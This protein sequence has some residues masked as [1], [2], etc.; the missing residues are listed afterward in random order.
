M[1]SSIGF[2]EE[3]CNRKFS[4]RYPLQLLLLSEYTHKQHIVAFHNNCIYNIFTGCLICI[5]TF[6]LNKGIL[7]MQANNLY[8]Q[9]SAPLPNSL[10]CQFLRHEVS[11]SRTTKTLIDHFSTT[12][13]KRILR[14]DVLRIGMVDHYMVYG[15]RKVNAWRLK[16]KNKPKILETRSFTKYDKT[17]FINDL[18]QCEVQKE[19]ASINIYRT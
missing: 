14:A 9:L 16:G 18:R 5:E 10:I 7:E 13:P 12:S 3:I 19:D 11:T 15:I 8:E 1:L 2:F 6:Q 4:C 17:S